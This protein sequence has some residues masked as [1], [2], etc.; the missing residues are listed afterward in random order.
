VKHTLK[1]EPKELKIEP[2]YSADM[3]SLEADIL[4]NLGDES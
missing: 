3:Q 2:K 1:I 4:N